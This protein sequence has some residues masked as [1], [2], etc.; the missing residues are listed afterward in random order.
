MSSDVWPDASIGDIALLRVLAQG[1][2]GTWVAERLLDAPFRVAWPWI[3]DLERSVPLFDSDVDA[4]EVR[5]RD[6]DRL[7]VVA[8][9]P[10]WLGRSRIGFDVELRTGWCWMV[11]RNGLYVVGMA[12]EADGQRTR[13][14][15]LEG[16]TVRGTAWRRRLALPLLVLSRWRH[17]VH[18]E[19]DLDGIARN[20]PGRE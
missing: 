6:G 1:M 19:H 13:I 9:A 20:L 14:A 16:I 10:W 8:R 12:A 5:S 17:R 2:P 15:H 7:R 3:A 18:L 11:A 4:L